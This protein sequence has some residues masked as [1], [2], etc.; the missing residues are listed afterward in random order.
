MPTVGRFANILVTASGQEIKTI[1]VGDYDI[2]VTRG[3]EYCLDQHRIRISEGETTYLD[4]TLS[5]AIDT[6]GF[7]SADFHLH[8]QFAMRDGAMV[9]AAEG[10]DLLT[11]TD[12]NVSSRHYSSVPQVNC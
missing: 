2:Y 1:P 9:S 12:H 4:S 5:R 11:A 8:L 6:T 3:T 10:L 7:I